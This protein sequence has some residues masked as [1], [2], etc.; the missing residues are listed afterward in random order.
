MAACECTPLCQHCD[1]PLKYIQPYCSK[2]RTCSCGNKY[3]VVP[4]SQPKKFKTYCV[5]FI[6]IPCRTV[7]APGT[8]HAEWCPRFN[9]CANCDI[10]L[11]S[12]H[13]IMYNNVP[14]CPRITANVYRQLWDLWWMHEEKY[15]SQ[16]QW[17]PIKIS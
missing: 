6:H 13:H 17:L 10:P 14:H 1:A 12:Y 15:N 16:L 8:E 5:E 3:H 4:A 9:A 7:E 2:M 11:D